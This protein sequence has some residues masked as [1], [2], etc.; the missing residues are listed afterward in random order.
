MKV[1]KLDI[2]IRR[3]DQHIL[4]PPES[5]KFINLSNFTECII[6]VDAEDLE[7]RVYCE[8]FV[9]ELS[10]KAAPGM[11][12]IIRTLD[13]KKDIL[14]IRINFSSAGRLL[15][16][17]FVFIGW[18]PEAIL[19]ETGENPSQKSFVSTPGNYYLV[20][21][22]LNTLEDFFDLDQV[23][24]EEWVEA[25]YKQISLGESMH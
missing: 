9:L 4:I 15:N 2:H 14:D 6:P 25:A 10:C 21:N 11:D 13:E 12:K 23:E 3:D 8:L 17:L 22:P 1:S 20:I 18:A 16:S 24:Q 19:S 7:H 5:I